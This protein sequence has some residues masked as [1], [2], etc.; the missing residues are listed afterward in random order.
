M[1]TFLERILATKQREVNELKDSSAISH[2]RETGTL[3]ESGQEPAPCIGFRSALEQGNQLCVVAEIKQAS[4]SKG[5][6]SNDFHPELRAVTYERSGA[7]AI[8]VLTDRTFFHGSLHDLKLVRRSVR[9]PI[10]RKD[11]VID[12]SQI[13]EARL[14]GADAVLL[15]CA[16]L[17]PTRLL[18]LSRYAQSMGLDTLVE[19]HGLDEL[20]FALAANPSVLGVNNRNLHTF[21]VSL[22]TTLKILRHVPND[23]CVISESGID[24][25]SDAT[26]MA[27]AGAQGVLVGEAL[28]RQE[29]EDGAAGLLQSLRVRRRSLRVE[30]Q[31]TVPTGQ[32]R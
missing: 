19:V 24:N 20:D 28:M 13:A 25:V 18:E 14:A 17:S 2:F 32:S 7:T 31:N 1:T 15:I 10:L 23:L 9:L 29:S 8:S 26:C 3:L 27:E 21:E 16:A 30:H 6:I 5:Q 12:E 11:F 4:P 22:E